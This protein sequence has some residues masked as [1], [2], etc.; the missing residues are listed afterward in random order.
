MGK[1]ASPVFF[2]GGGVHPLG[3]CHARARRSPP[4][5]QPRS[6]RGLG[7]PL[8]LVVAT[9]FA[10]ALGECR[11]A[12]FS[13]RPH[14][15]C[16]RSP[17][18]ATLFTW[19][20]TPHRW[21]A[22]WWTTETRVAQEQEWCLV[23]G[24]TRCVCGMWTPSCASPRCLVTRDGLRASQCLRTEGAGLECGWSLDLRTGRRGYGIS[25]CCRTWRRLLAT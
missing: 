5:W 12:W 16:R 20:A 19:L 25:P 14:G 9:L 18:A 7:T 22:L 8:P 10:A 2:F 21:H 3:E 13:S 15:R 6:G 17:S 24:T 4:H 23:P 1:G 11:S